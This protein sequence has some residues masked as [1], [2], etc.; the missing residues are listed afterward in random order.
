ALAG[1]QAGLRDQRVVRG[2]ERLG[3][4]PGDAQ[5]EA[6]RHRGTVLGPGPDVLRLRP[7]ADDPE[8]AVAGRR[9]GH[10][11]ARL[12]DDAG[13]LQPGHVGRRVGRR[14]VP[15]RPLEQVGPVQ[16]GPVDPDE[17]LAGAR[18]GPLAVLDG[19]P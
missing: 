4:T 12:L 3:D 6:L 19:Q 17:A 7:A 2:H 11:R 5:V 15:A 9:L 1:L 14:W 10:A 18:P 13:E 8:H 16:T